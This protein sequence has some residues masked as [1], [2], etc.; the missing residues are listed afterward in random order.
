LKL[1]FGTSNYWLP[2]KSIIWRKILKCFPQNPEEKDMNILDDMGVSKLSGNFYL[3]FNNGTY[4][5]YYD[6]I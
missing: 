5:V 6:S 4:L 1:I 2:L 3:K